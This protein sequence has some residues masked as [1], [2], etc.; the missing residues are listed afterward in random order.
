[1]PPQK[2]THTTHNNQFVPK[3][4]CF[5]VWVDLKYYTNTLPTLPTIRK[6]LGKCGYCG[7]TVCSC[8]GL[9]EI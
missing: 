2:P 5:L 8:V 3:L 4:R 6:F 1:M 7:Y 9:D